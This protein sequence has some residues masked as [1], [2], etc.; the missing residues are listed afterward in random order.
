MSRALWN[1]NV[2]NDLQVL[3][4]ASIALVGDDL[5]DDLLKLHRLLL[6][7]IQLKEVSQ[8]QMPT[9]EVQQANARSNLA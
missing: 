8:R 4:H 6:I 3:A 7:A 5:T 2:A 1:L 9:A